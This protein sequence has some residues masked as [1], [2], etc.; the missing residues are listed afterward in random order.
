M[1]AL[2][3]A[4]GGDAD[5]DAVEEQRTSGVPLIDN[6]KTSGGKSQYERGRRKL[7]TTTHTH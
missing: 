3:P 4:V 7:I 1:A 6:D 2:L 5:C